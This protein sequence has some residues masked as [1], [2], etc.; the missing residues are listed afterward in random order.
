MTEVQ[1]GREGGHASRQ[2]WCE[3]K[4][5]LAG[6]AAVR[7]VRFGVSGNPWRQER[8]TGSGGEGMQAYQDEYIANLRE[9]A[10]LTMGRRQEG[11][12]FED[13]LKQAD[14]EKRQAEE[15]GKRNMLL[16]RDRKS[17]V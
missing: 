11:Q 14:R 12:S 3:R 15:K 16:L 6:K 7:A 10:S 1:G 8:R 4:S 13:Y 9:I 5:G 2:V 17:V